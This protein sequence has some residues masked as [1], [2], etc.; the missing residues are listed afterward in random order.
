MKSSILTGLTF[1]ALALLAAPAFAQAAPFGHT[2]AATLF[3]K[4]NVVSV[5]LEDA[6]VR[7]VLG[8]LAKKGGVSLVMSDGVTGKISIA[9]KGVPLSEVFEMVL[10]QA[11]LSVERSG[12]SLL[13]FRKC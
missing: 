6:S 2:D 13:V 12:N 8:I 4:T 11:G 5:E 9:V 1:A 10:K 7:Q 3:P